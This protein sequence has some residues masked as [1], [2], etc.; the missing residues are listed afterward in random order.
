MPIGSPRTVNLT[1]NFVAE[2][3]GAGAPPMIISRAR[4]WLL[5]A[6]LGNIGSQTIEREE[7]PGPAQEI[8]T[9]GSA[10]RG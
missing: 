6:Q 10:S 2:P 8:I 5:I 1:A 7:G 3:L 9:T 4:L